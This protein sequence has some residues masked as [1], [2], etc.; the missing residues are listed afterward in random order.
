MGAAGVGG[1][2]GGLIDFTPDVLA[3]AF[4][5]SDGKKEDAVE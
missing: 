2:I 4:R 1:C 5:K 3:D